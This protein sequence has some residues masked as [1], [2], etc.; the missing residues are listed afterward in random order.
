M[1]RCE[2]C[3]RHHHRTEWACPFCSQAV[4]RPGRFATLVVAAA[5]SIVMGAC[6][7]S[8]SIPSPP[9][10]DATADVSDTSDTQGTAGETA[11]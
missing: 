7:G 3:G 4:A 10:P 1:R 2:N 5:S 8:P 6:Y 11:E 9:A